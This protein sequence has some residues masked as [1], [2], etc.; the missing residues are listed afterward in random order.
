MSERERAKETKIEKAER[1]REKGI[2]R[3]KS[4]KK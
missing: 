2:L 4:T 3:N 1:E